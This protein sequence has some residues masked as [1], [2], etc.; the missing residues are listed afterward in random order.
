MREFKNRSRPCIKTAG[1]TGTAVESRAGGGAA[2]G[3]IAIADFAENSC[4]NRF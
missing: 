2:A 1:K 3:T 4:Q